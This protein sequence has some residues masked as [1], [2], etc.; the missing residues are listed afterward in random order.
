MN[1][2]LIWCPGTI[3]LWEID[4]NKRSVCSQPYEWDLCPRPIFGE[5]KLLIFFQAL[6]RGNQG[7]VRFTKLTLKCLV[8]E[9]FC[10]GPGRG[11][12]MLSSKAEALKKEKMKAVWLTQS[13]QFKLTETITT[14]HRALTHISVLPFFISFVFVL[15]HGHKNF[16]ITS[17]HTATVNDQ[18]CTYIVNSATVSFA[19]WEWVS[20]MSSECS[21]RE[22]VVDLPEQE[23]ECQLSVSDLPSQ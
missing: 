21:V 1:N 18:V 5:T 16:S 4:E 11:Q 23:E 13:R 7:L 15:H 6:L 19:C 9:I 12:P 2:S 22:V 14:R 20:G 10:S 8:C 3:L 17:N